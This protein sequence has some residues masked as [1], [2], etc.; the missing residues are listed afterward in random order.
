MEIRG[1]GFRMGGDGWQRNLLTLGVGEILGKSRVLVV[2]VRSGIGRR[3]RLS[4]EF[5]RMLSGPWSS[6]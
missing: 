2:G 3:G 5:G 4:S 1:E 6:V